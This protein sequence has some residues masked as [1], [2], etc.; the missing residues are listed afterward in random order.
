VRC[1]L[2]STVVT[3]ATHFFPTANE[4][5]YKIFQQLFRDPLSGFVHYFR[6]RLDKVLYVRVLYNNTNSVLNV[7]DEK[8]MPMHERLRD[9]TK[10]L[11]T[12]YEITS[13]TVQFLSCV[14]VWA[15]ILDK[16]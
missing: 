5:S 10:T 8:W 2:H 15:R 12:S 1:N 6:S 9:N 13:K 3:C 14:R 11:T 4:Q 16:S 7:T